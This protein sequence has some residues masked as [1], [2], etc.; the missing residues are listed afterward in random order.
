MGNHLGVAVASLRTSITGDIRVIEGMV[1]GLVESLEVAGGSQGQEIEAAVP[2]GFHCSLGALIEGVKC[3]IDQH[4]AAANIFR[5]QPEQ[6]CWSP[7]IRPPARVV[8]QTVGNAPV[9][10][11]AAAA[12]ARSGVVA[13]IR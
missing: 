11:A 10:L 4:K 1:Q 2:A 13:G 3:K 12:P 5:A 8:A 6:Q 7:A 9:S